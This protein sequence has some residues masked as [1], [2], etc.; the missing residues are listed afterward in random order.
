[1]ADDDL[2]AFAAGMYLIIKDGREGICKDGSS[3][4]E[5]QTVLSDVALSFC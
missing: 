3:L 1:M 4:I 2:T 5:S